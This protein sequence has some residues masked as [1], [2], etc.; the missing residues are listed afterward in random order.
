MVSISAI[1]LNSSTLK[2]QWFIHCFIKYSVK[3]SATELVHVIN[4]VAK[5][6]III[7][8]WLIFTTNRKAKCVA[9]NNG[10]R[11]EWSPIRSVIIQ[12]FITSM[13]T[14]RIGRHGVLLPI[15]HKNYN[16]REKK[17]TKVWKGKIYTVCIVIE[18]KVVIGWF[19]LQLK[20]DWLI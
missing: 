16:F 12:V 10:N 1:G 4:A 9:I 8:F 17:N 6:K 18:T 13:I 20:C 7:G 19:K 5:K 2:K 14:D 3:R 11:T 15:N